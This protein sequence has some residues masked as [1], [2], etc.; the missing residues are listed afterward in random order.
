MKATHRNNKN[1][2]N[3]VQRKNKKMKNK[4]IIIKELSKTK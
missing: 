1:I 3:K 4:E 2:C